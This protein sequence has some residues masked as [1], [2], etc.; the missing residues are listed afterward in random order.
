MEFR[1]VITNVLKTQHVKRYA[2]RS[3]QLTKQ[4][5]LLGSHSIGIMVLFLQNTTPGKLIVWE[6]WEELYLDANHFTYYSLM[7]RLTETAEAI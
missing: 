3:I 7:L 5:F 2:C 6:V 4:L 1:T